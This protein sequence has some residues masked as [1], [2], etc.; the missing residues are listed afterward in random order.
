VSIAQKLRQR[1]VDR[2]QQEADDVPPMMSWNEASLE[3]ELADQL[4]RWRM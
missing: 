2:V 1:P 4:A 3:A